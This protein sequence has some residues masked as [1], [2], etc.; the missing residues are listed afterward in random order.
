M[1]QLIFREKLRQ[2]V[3]ACF[4][5][6]DTLHSLLYIIRTMYISIFLDVHSLFFYWWSS[7][8]TEIGKLELSF[9][10]SQKL[11]SKW[12][13]QTEFSSG[14]MFLRKICLALRVK[15]LLPKY[16]NP[17]FLKQRDWNETKSICSH[18][19][20]HNKRWFIVARAF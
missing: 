1:P 7:H 11:E 14:F 13:A 3:V 12:L 17:S 6:L 16:H 9:V 2:T 8:V 5:L 20:L 18:D 15:W 10:L 19:Y 4:I